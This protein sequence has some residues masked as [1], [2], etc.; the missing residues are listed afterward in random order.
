L[1]NLPLD[2]LKIDKSFIQGISNGQGK[3]VI[4]DTIIGMAKHLGFGVIA[5]GVE[6]Q[7]E[8]NFL[9]KSGCIQYQGYLFSRPLPADAFFSFASQIYQHV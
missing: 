8:L 9:K 6:H 4:V 1:H 3:T 2:Q 7:V 5:E